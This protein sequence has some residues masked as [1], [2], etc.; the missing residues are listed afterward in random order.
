[1]V[2]TVSDF[3]WVFLPYCLLRQDDGSYVVCNR[4]H[5]PVGDARTAFVDYEPH[6][7]IRFKRLTAA[8]VRKLDYAGREDLA[9]IEL[10]NDGCVPTDSQAKWDSYSARLQLLAKLKVEAV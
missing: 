9:R 6:V 1:M 10:Y 2:T 8:I 7:R 4:R 5:K 3:R